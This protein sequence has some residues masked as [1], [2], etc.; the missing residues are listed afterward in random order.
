MCIYQ[1]IENKLNDVNVRKLKS[2]SSTAFDQ[3]PEFL[4]K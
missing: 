4:L 2:K 3:I 1:V